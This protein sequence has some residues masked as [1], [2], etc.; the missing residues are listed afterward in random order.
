MNIRSSP[1]G[2]AARYAL[3]G[4]ARAPGDPY[5]NRTQEAS[6]PGLFLSGLATPS[7]HHDPKANDNA[8]IQKKIGGG[9]HQELSLY[10]TQNG[11]H[12]PRTLHA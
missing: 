12:L 1:L 8:F 6:L 3:T 9:V 4:T 7:F 5:M 2:T 10:H 11:H